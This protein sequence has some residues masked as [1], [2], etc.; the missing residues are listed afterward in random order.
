MSG[1]NGGPIVV[2]TVPSGA[3]LLPKP[4]VGQAK[5]LTSSGS[6][7]PYISKSIG[8]FITQVAPGPYCDV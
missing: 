6:I 4:Q 5:S 8:S 1:R 7:V 2:I 3:V